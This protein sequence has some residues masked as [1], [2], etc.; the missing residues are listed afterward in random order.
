MLYFLYVTFPSL[1]LDCLWTVSRLSLNCLW[2][3]YGCP[4]S[5]NISPRDKTIYPQCFSLNPPY[6]DSVYK[7]PI[8]WRFGWFCFNSFFWSLQSSLLYI[9]G[10]LAGYCYC[11]CGVFQM[12]G[13]MW[14]AT[15]DTL[16]RNINRLLLHKVLPILRLVMGCFKIVKESKNLP[17]TN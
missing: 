8:L 11:D 3:V 9:V 15:H 17:T 7:S 10:E 2:T 13:Y 14:H 6:A 12:T 5:I 1:S 16:H 4:K